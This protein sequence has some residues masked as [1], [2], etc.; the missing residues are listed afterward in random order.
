MFTLAKQSKELSHNMLLNCYICT[1]ADIMLYIYI[2]KSRAKQI[3][4]P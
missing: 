2:K 1:S 4:K 3:T